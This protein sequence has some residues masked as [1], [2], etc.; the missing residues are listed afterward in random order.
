[1]KRIL[2]IGGGSIG[3][4]H[5]RCFLRT[6]RAE[7]G[8]CDVNEKLRTDVAQR[9]NVKQ[10]YSTLNDALSAEFDAAVICT[11]ADLHIPMAIDIAGRNMGILIEKPLSISQERIDELKAVVE[12]KQLAVS[13]AY[14]LRHHPALLA[15]KQY[16]NGGAFGRPVQVVFTGGQHFPFYRPAYRGTYYTRRATG[17]GAIQD[18]L[19]HIVNAAEWI[20]G[21]ITRL[22]A[23]AEHFILEGVDVEDTVHL[24][25]RHNHVMGSF[26]LNQHQAPNETTLTIICEHGT[27]RYEAHAARWLT[28]S[29]PNSPW[30]VE[31]EF[32]F[33]RDD[34]FLTQANAF[35]NQ[36][37]GS[38]GP[39]CSLDEARQTLCA[40]LAALKSLETGTW[41][42]L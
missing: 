9:Y 23:D 30:K 3:E 24:V 6:G 31:E 26:S 5:L 33:E 1:M 29:E 35:L 10:V 16:L 21:P 19:T 11:P 8:L 18:A 40:N 7:V 34:M 15:M 4:R 22:V 37:E 39:A 27:V 42:K 20:V 13:V 14:V 2:I 32:Q 38:A 17:G 12:S 41:I 28:C 36:L 25:T